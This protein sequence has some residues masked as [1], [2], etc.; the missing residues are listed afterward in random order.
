M[1]LTI[2][3]LLTVALRCIH[4]VLMDYKNSTLKDGLKS[5]ETEQDVFSIILKQNKE[6]RK[7]LF[8]IKFEN[9]IDL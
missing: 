8:G 7:N 3:V 2:T 5:K 4:S 6:L 9:K 1:D